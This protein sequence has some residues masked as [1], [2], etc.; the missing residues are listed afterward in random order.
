MQIKAGSDMKVNKRTTPR[1]KMK[2]SLVAKSSTK[3]FKQIQCTIFILDP[4]M[5]G[6]ENKTAGA[7]LLAGTGWGLG[8]VKLWEEIPPM[9]CVD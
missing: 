8:E 3:A 2:F 7:R 9:Q 5:L 4:L 1:K 6:G